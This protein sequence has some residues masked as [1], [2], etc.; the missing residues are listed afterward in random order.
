M[1]LIKAAQMQMSIATHSCI[2][3]MSHLMLWRRSVHWMAGDRLLDT[4]HWAQRHARPLCSFVFNRYI[5]V[6]N[7]CEL[8]SCI[9]HN[10]HQ[11]IF[12][13]VT[14]SYL[15]SWEWWRGEIATTT[16]TTT[17]RPRKMNAT[18][19]EG[20]RTGAQT[21]IMWPTGQHIVT[22]LGW[23]RS[24]AQFSW[25]INLMLRVETWSS[26]GEQ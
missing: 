6:F 24:P 4:L 20:W 11:C 23:S 3:C 15:Y 16:T 19:S 5:F 2:A 17:T 13:L 26:C 22:Q 9:S 12:V 10:N 18:W 21:K 7:R 14:P 25:P 8:L 1:W